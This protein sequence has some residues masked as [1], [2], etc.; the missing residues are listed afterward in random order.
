MNIRVGI[1]TAKQIRYKLHGNYLQKQLPD[2]T[3]FE[4]QDSDCYFELEDVTIGIDFHWQRNETQSFRGALKIM[5]QGVNQQAVNILDIEDYLES[6][7][8]SEM[9][10]TSSPELLKTHAIISRSWA[11]NAILQE[12]A[13]GTKSASPTPKSRLIKFYER[14]AHT[15]FDVCADDHC[16]RYQGIT[17]ISSDNV[18]QAIE[19][20]RGLILKY[21]GKVADARFYKCCGGATELFE[22]VWADN[23]HPYLISQAD[24]FNTSLP[25]LTNEE[26][27]REWIVSSPDA[28]CNTTDKNILSQV[29]NNYDQETPDF[30]R[31]TVSYTQSQLS[32]L[33]NGKSGIDFGVIQDL[34]PVKR[35]PSGR[36]IELQIT[37]SKKSLIIGKELEIR[38]WLSP[39]HLYSSA[40]V[41]DR[42]DQQDFILHGAGWGHGVGLCQIGAAMMAHEGYNYQQILQHYFPHTTIEQ[43]SS[44]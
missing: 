29:L 19:A 2:G 36:I 21:N 39:T 34:K 6:V 41:I 17:R 25:D 4:P 37:G 16:Q 28:F 14:D 27:A 8:A 9:S 32:E 26:N 23:H 24:T 31:W 10:A 11:I 18:H 15:D 33:I 40:F 22:N 13:Q 42:N 5:N 35:G 1:M 12:S 43:L 7:I 3:L 30:Y 38:K 20:T 44:L